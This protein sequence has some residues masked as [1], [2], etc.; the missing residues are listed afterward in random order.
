[1]VM[2]A[3]GLALIAL[4]SAEHRATVTQELVKLLGADNE[5]VRKRASEALTEMAAD[6][7]PASK[8]S[9]SLKDGVPLVSVLKEGLIDGRVEA[10]EYALRSLLSVTDAASKE[11]IVEAGCVPELIASLTGQK[12]KAVAQEHAA[13]VLSG[14]APLGD[15]A[16]LIK[17]EEGIEPLV[18]LL[19]TGNAE[20]KVH[21]ANVLAQLAV[22]A[23]AA[24]EIAKAGAVSAFVKWLS[25]PTL[26]P[27]EVAAR[28]LSEIA[29]GNPDTQTQIAEEGA[30]SHLVSMLSNTKLKVANVAAGALATLS[31]EHVINQLM[32]TEL[33][34]L[35]PLVDLLKA[36]TPQHKVD[37]YE[38]ATK[39]LW[40]LAATFDNQTA[41]A[42]AGGIAPL[43]NL[44]TSESEVTQQYA[45]AALESLV[46]DHSENQL[47]LARAGAIQPLVDILGSDSAET[48]EHAVASLLYLA[49]HD[50][51]TCNAVVKRLVAVLDMRSAAAQMKA[52]EALAVLASRSDENRKVI[53]AASAIDPLVRLLGDGRRVRTA[54]P[55]ERAAAVLADL[56]RAGDNKKT[57][58]E[59]GGVAPLIAMLSSGSPEAQTH[60]A[61]ALWHLAALGPNKMVIA[62][63]GAIP[64]LVSLLSSKAVEAQKYSTG[65]LWHLASS[66][67][68]KTQMVAAGAI[69]LLVSVLSSKSG[70]TREHAAAI[71]SALARSQGGNKKTIYTADGIRPLIALLMDN[72]PM[73]QRHAACSLWALSD[74]KDGVYD[75]QIA[76]GGAI[77][78]LVAMMQN[79]DTETRGFAAACLLCLCRDQTA[80]AAILESGAVE[81]LQ[82]L[83]YGPA[84][85]LRTQVVEMLTLLGTEIPDPDAYSLIAP[86]QSF[87]DYEGSWG[88]TGYTPWGQPD[89]E[90]EGVSSP[91]S[92]ARGL[93]SRITGRNPSAR[94]NPR[95]PPP[96]QRQSAQMSGTA[97]MKFHFFS[98]Q[99]YGT[100]G[101]MGH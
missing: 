4:K 21:A 96:F 9:A 88:N 41:I 74:G 7:S 87:G 89:G 25:D 27:P 38:L 22:R 62:N 75:K 34:G 100:T 23:K 35:R 95:S 48:Q 10:V 18:V 11:A 76:E 53:T 91:D 13:A 63:A 60:A 97:R 99:I 33:G 55:Q 24:L 83:A 66:A 49:S 47:A 14:L 36:R 57:I 93:S 77:P 1:M 30:I 67:D 52:A 29:L 59:V 28:A 73:T 32:I 19:S 98:F 92:S 65:A 61:G 15:N 68:N 54:T 64:P 3:S 31:K 37:A 86:P 17:T 46:R 43:V 39:A 71:I 79:D 44:L 78:L 50:G 56:A 72:R 5:A 42:K 40:H 16:R 69:P 84:T 20:A 70:E 58:V 82:A 85:W 51:E 2:A 80:H 94:G 26:G 81:P 101:Y 45:A 6:D 90:G 12:L 8:K